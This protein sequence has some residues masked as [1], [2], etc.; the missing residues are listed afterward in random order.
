MIR[1]YK[2]FGLAKI[3]TRI[4]EC[5]A[6]LRPSCTGMFKGTDRTK[7]GMDTAGCVMF[8]VQEAGSGKIRSVVV[9]RKIQLWPNSLRVIRAY[10]TACFG[11]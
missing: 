9:K 10:V 1:L 3:Q 7:S 4:C 6:D 5:F 8:Y 11:Y 2:E